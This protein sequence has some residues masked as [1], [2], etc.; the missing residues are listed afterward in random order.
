MTRINLKTGKLIK[1]QQFKG[2]NP[3]RQLQFY[4]EKHI[5]ELL[6]CYFLK[7][8]YKIPGGEI[9]TL[10]ITEDGIPCIIEYKHKQ[11]D[12]ILNQVV[13]YYDWLVQKSSKFEFE[14]I[15]KE[16]KTTKDIEID[17]SQIRLVCIAESY[18]KWD[19]SLIKHL[20][21]PIECMTYTYH[22]DELDI[23]LD[24]I[25]NQFVKQKSY[26]N[27]Q[28]TVKELTLEDHRN[29]ADEDCKKIL[30]KFRE[31]VLK[32]GDDITEGY[33]PNYIKYFVNTNFLE[34]HIRRKWIIACFKPD[35]KNFTDPQKLA[36]DISHLKFSVTREI[37][38]SNEEELKY[39]LTLVKQ[40]YN[41]QK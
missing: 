27:K 20:D 16:N 1:L 14:R 19:I 4:V 38:I 32:M 24:P 2:G 28:T 25:I 8:F 7:S 6:Q 11:E 15:V 29:R 31:N 41:F 26:E 35:E 30:D 37:K 21:T 33:T 9:D 13:F 39:A 17:W 34:V 40:A 22:E 18:F 5:R 23:H 36:K 3:E 12:K 10:A